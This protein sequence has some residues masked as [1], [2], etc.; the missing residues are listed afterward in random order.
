MASARWSAPSTP[1]RPAPTST[2]VCSSPTPGT[3]PPQHQT[4]L[5]VAGTVNHLLLRNFCAA[6]D[7]TEPDWP[8]E[9][10]GGTLS[11]LGFGK[12]VAT[13]TGPWHELLPLNM[14]GTEENGAAWSS[15]DWM[16]DGDEDGAVHMGRHLEGIQVE[17]FVDLAKAEEVIRTCWR[18]IGGW[19]T[20]PVYAAPSPNGHPDGQPFTSGGGCEL[21]VIRADDRWTSPH[22]DR[23]TMAVHLTLGTKFDMPRILAACEEMEAALHAVDPEVNTALARLAVECAYS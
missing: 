4:T 3:H 1:S 8:G 5:C 10:L 7:L 11:E 14:D 20:N 17:Y 16:A 22:R 9:Y 21:R 2:Q 12:F 6:D 23:D 15:G 19:Q 13:R 18:V